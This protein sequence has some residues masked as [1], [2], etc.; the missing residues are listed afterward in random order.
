[1][2]INVLKDF[3]KGAKK[4]LNEKIFIESKIIDNNKTNQE[5]FRIE[6]IDRESR[7]IDLPQYVDEEYFNK[8]WK[9]PESSY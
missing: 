4:I 1:M 3:Q 5:P 9:R 7:S 6:N 2:D 8:Y